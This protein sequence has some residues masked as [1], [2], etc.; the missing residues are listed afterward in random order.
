MTTTGL[1]AEAVW[2]VLE[3]LGWERFDDSDDGYSEDR[4]MLRDGGI[5]I[6]IRCRHGR[7]DLDVDDHHSARVWVNL[8]TNELD[9]A[10]AALAQLIAHAAEDGK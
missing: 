6:S 5:Q 2:R 9:P 3:P 10:L 4:F 7:P 8:D 1:S